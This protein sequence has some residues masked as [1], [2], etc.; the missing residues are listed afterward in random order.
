MEVHVNKRLLSYQKGGSMRRISDFARAGALAMIMSALAGIQSA[1]AQ[2]TDLPIA[3]PEKV[4]FSSERLKQ[5]DA[6]MQQAVAD[7]QYGG[8]VVLLARHGKVIRFESFGKPGRTEYAKEAI[9]RLASMSKPITGAAMMLLY[10]EGKWG[11]KDPVS[12]FIPEFASLKVFKDL[13]DFGR[14]RVEE[15]EHAPTMRELMT[16]TA[17]LSSG[18]GSSPVDQLYRDKAGNSIFDP[19][20]SLQAMIQQLAKAPLLYHP[21]TRWVYGISVD[22]QGYIIEKLSRMTLPEFLRKRLFEPLGMKDSGFYVPKEK[23]NRF[24]T[25]YRVRESDKGEVTAEALSNDYS[26]IELFPLDYT[27]EPSQPSGGGGM[28]STAEDYFRFAQMLLNQGEFNGVRILSPAAV[29]LMTSNH[30]PDNMTSA[31]KSIVTNTPRL[32]MGYGYDGAVV[33]DAAKADLPIGNGSYMWDGAF[34]TWFWVDP[35]NDIVFVGMVQRTALPG[36][37]LPDAYTDLQELSKVVIYQ[38]LL[39]PAS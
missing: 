35:A 3:T 12:K 9:F 13:D 21:S 33:I 38:A 22:I 2:G 7:K 6:L 29:K 17:G 4:G 24:A 20:S 26:P 28:V 34:G 14:I 1:R 27:R 18:F 19:R 25:L 23:W 11:P 30:L 10:D 32:G 8:I 39:R 5:L 37:K 31:Y 36:D 16:H 15:P